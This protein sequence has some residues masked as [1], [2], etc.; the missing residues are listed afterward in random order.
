M[1]VK[2]QGVWGPVRELKEA[3]F[4]QVLRAQKGQVAEEAEPQETKMPP[5]LEEQS[6]SS[7]YPLRAFWPQ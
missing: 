2:T 3:G 6:E 1:K 4:G 7:H 5:A